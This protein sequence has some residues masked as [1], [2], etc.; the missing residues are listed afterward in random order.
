MARKFFR[1]SAPLGRQF[2]T[3]MGDTLSDPYTVV[4]VVEDAKYRDL[5]EADSK[6]AY[7]PAT[8]GASGGSVTLEVRADGDPLLLIPSL[9]AVIADV[10]RAAT[11]S[12]TPLDT[13]VA[14]SLQRERVL[15]VLSGLFGATALALAML[16]LY[17]V[18]TYTVARRRNEIGVRIALG[19]DRSRVLRMILGD[20][21]RVVAV[22][23]VVGVMGAIASGKLVTSFLYGLT[24]SD[25]AIVALAAAIL[26]VV[27]LGAGL[28]PAL[29]ASRVDP[30]AA[31]RED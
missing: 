13:Q 30:V 20:V 29:R 14:Q 4:G 5:R 23:L 18:M 10:H 31:L 19:A 1:D 21:A 22:G 9:K 8:Q 12:F 24:P 15:A 25:P 7:L 16:G 17:G 27:A 2:R 6:T 26:A 3:R 28:A 11:V